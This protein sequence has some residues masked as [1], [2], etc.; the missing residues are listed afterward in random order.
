MAATPPLKPRRP[1]GQASRPGGGRD[2]PLIQLIPNLVTLSALCLGLTAMRFA[3][4]GR[5]EAAVGL[6]LLAALLDALDGGLAR[7]LASESAIGAELD[8]LS[9]FLSFGVAPGFVLY[10]AGLGA[11]PA[12]GWMA[13]LIL[14]LACALRL[15]R[16]N[17]AAA[18]GPA[19]KAWFRGVPAPAGALLALAPL[20]LGFMTGGAFA[21][22]ALALA[23]W[24]AF[25]AALMISTLPTWSVK[26]WA[27]RAEHAPYLL[28]AVLTLAILLAFFPWQILTLA[29]GLYLLS[30]P[31]AWRAARRS[32][33]D[34]KV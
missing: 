19:S 22:P 2:L 17:V 32:R 25:I 24:A 21:P 8:S 10:Y 27:I 26:A 18:A 11:L 13:V 28:L 3:V 31:L 9:D 4:A 1:P 29:A 12:F 30:L 7:L 20:Y 14:A 16:F 23:L 5:I 15:A 34:H 33:K 6:I